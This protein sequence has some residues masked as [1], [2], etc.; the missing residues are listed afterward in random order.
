VTFALH[1][2]LR[3]FQRLPVFAGTRLENGKVSL[4]VQTREEAAP[5]CGEALPLGRDTEIT[6]YLTP[7]ITLPA[8]AATLLHEMVHASGLWRHD[9]RFKAR[10][11]EATREAFPEAPLPAQA[12][13]T[14]LSPGLLDE[15]VTLASTYAAWHRG[16]VSGLILASET[17]IAGIVVGS[18][19]VRR[20][21]AWA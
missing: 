17:G 15:V 21:R 7:G 6:V 1:Q 20:V 14:R 11:A 3:R 12:W 16:E 19:A 4:I 8:A 10:L 5:W 9:R 13:L 2:Y 18:A